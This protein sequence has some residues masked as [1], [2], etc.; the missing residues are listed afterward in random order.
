MRPLGLAL[1]LAGAALG[2]W[3]GL[4]PWWAVAW[5]VLALWSLLLDRCERC[6]EVA[7]RCGDP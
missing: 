7:C 6:G 3:L 2:V 1:M 5:V 4:V